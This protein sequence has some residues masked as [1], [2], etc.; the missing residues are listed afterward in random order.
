MFQTALREYFEIP[1]R[2]LS[3]PSVSLW[4]FNAAVRELKRSGIESVDEEAI[5]ET[6]DVLQNIEEAAIIKAAKARRQN[7]R[8]K[9]HAPAQQP[10]QNEGL[11]VVNDNAPA[12]DDGEFEL[13]DDDIQ[14]DWEEWT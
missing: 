11:R 3:K 5:F 14:N 2:D 8:R 7:Q 1:Y 13:D 6:L 9:N 12:D 10:N 4:E